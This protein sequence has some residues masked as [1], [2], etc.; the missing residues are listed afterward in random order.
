M[1]WGTEYEQGQNRVRYNKEQDVRGL[2]WSE[3]LKKY[4]HNSETGEIKRTGR[5][6]DSL[7]LFSKM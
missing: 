5:F 2:P 1:G 6:L 4:N 7:A 3:T